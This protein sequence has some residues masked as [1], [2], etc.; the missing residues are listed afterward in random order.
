MEA[1]SL[2]DWSI[3][4]PL[5]IIFFKDKNIVPDIVP[6]LQRFFSYLRYNLDFSISTYFK[7]IIEYIVSIELQKAEHLEKLVTLGRGSAIL[8]K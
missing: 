5:S 2:I 6:Y 8:A 1:F 7:H 3:S 4:N